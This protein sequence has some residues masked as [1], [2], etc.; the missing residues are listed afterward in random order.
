[1]ID[2]SKLYKSVQIGR[3][4]IES[5]RKT[6]GTN[7]RNRWRRGMERESRSILFTRAVDAGGTRLEEISIVGL[8]MRDACGQKN[9]ALYSIIIVSSRVYRY[10]RDNQG[11]PRDPADSY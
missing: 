9:G 3:R 8:I 5:R 10:F 4:R 7:A 2:D 11:S 6:E 1:M